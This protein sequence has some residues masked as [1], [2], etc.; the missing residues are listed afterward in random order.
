MPLW[1]PFSNIVRG[2]FHPDCGLFC[3]G[4]T[5]R[6]FSFLTG[7]EAETLRILSHGIAYGG[8]QTQH[9]SWS[10]KRDFSPPKWLANAPPMSLPGSGKSICAVFLA[11]PG[12]YARQM[13]IILTTLG[14]LRTPGRW[15][16]CFPNPLCPLS[17]ASWPRQRLI[18]LHCRCPHPLLIH[19]PTNRAIR[20]PQ[21]R[22]RG[23]RRHYGLRTCWTH[24]QQHPSPH[25]LRQGVCP[26]WF[27]VLLILSVTE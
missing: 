8:A 16:V 3:F 20:G 25:H 14:H 11:C 23:T 22:H 26:Q 13:V 1:T 19:G 7:E 12:G 15:P 6:D 5:F 17:E 18:A 2:G 9:K 24:A 4:R 27:I 10:K 21:L